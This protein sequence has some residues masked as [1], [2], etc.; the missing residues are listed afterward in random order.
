MVNIKYVMNIKNDRVPKKAL[1][2]FTLEIITPTPVKNATTIKVK[3]AVTINLVIYSE[4]IFSLIKSVLY[5]LIKIFLGYIL[6]K[7]FLDL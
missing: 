7:I 6:I 1:L 4:F 5:I 2:G 3:R